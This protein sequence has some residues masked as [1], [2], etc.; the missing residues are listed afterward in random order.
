MNAIEFR[1]VDILFARDRG[2]RGERALADAIARLDGGAS[3]D[4]ISESCGV[5]VGV[6]AQASRS[7]RARSA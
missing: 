3:R 6:G 2:R 5:I 4:E 7:S 1:D